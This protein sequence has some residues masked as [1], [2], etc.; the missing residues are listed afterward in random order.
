MFAIEHHIITLKV[1][2]IQY[3]SSRVFHFNQK[4][5]A[6]IND[7]NAA[8]NNEDATIKAAQFSQDIFSQ[9][10]SKHN[11]QVLLIDKEL[12]TKKTA[13]REL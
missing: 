13:S 2:Q 11:T 5:A 4:V 10:R 7:I 12:E 1:D 9:E 6:S 8:R 3:L